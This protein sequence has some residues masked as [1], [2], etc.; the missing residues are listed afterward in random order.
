VEGTASMSEKFIG[1]GDA[2]KGL[3]PKIA[4]RSGESR[5]VLVR[6]GS[7]GCWPRLRGTRLVVQSPWAPRSLGWRR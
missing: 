5:T 7:V 3:N 4:L 1:G 6:R 2:A